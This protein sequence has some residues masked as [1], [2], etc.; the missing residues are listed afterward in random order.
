MLDRNVP[1]PA[2]HQLHEAVLDEDLLL[3][4]HGVPPGLHYILEDLEAKVTNHGVAVIA[5]KIE[6]TL[7]SIRRV[8]LEFLQLIKCLKT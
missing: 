4:H 7:R 5:N 1:S 3:G 6:A 8:F 2:G